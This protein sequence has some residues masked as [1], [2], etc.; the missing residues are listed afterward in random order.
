MSSHQ[1]NY[2]P[3]LVDKNASTSLRTYR[4]PHCPG[5]L[6]ILS[7][8]GIPLAT[9]DTGI[10]GYFISQV[11]FEYITDALHLRQKNGPTQPNGYFNIVT[12]VWRTYTGGNEEV[13]VWLEGLF[14][15]DLEFYVITETGFV[16]ELEKSTREWTTLY[17]FQTQSHY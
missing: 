8:S 13:S 9:S 12:T 2:E 4:H 11:A 5:W 16:R 15:S 17:L 10:K 1:S 14:S 3:R 7:N 6:I